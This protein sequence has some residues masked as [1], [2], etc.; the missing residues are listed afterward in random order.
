VAVLGAGLG[1]PDG[2]GVRAAGRANHLGRR[3]ADGERLP[4]G[5]VRGGD[6]AGRLEGRG[7]WRGPPGQVDTVGRR[8][9]GGRQQPCPVQRECPGGAARVDGRLADGERRARPGGVKRV[10]E[11]R[12]EERHV[13]EASRELLRDQ[14][15]L[16]P[17]G[18]IGAQRPPPAAGDGLLE[19][20]GAHRIG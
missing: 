12:P 1:V 17:A 18:A 7:Q 14:R 8:A 10:G 15:D 19:P 5:R 16:H 4:P 20:G 11:D 3:N 6:L 9:D 2:E 13:D